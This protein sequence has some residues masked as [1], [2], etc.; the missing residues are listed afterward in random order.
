MFQSPGAEALKLGP[1]SIHWYGIL[2]AIAFLV[3]IFICSKV[4]RDKG[5]NPESFMDLAP[6]VLISAIVGARIYYVIFNWAYYSD[7]L[8]NIIKIWEGGLAIHGGIIGGL[9]AGYSYTRFKHLSFL[10]YCDITCVGLVIGQAIGRWGNFFNSEA[11]GIPT[12]LP[13]KLFIPP[14]KRPDE[15]INYDYFHP[16]FLYESLWDLIIFL[17]LYFVLRKKLENYNGALFFSYMGLYS[18]GRL[19]IESLRTDSLM[20]FNEIKAAQIISIVFIVIS[21]I[22]IKLLVKRK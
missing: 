8:L 1:L 10:K 18:I 16:T 2:I 6:L 19:F 22:G 5:E 20:L 21:V 7:N 11:F 3:G 14:D 15:F 13:W 4:A 17:I 12:D 9:I